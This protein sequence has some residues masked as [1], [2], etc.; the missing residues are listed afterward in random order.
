MRWLISTLADTVRQDL[1]YGVRMMRRGPM[2]SLTAVA[3]VA[4]STAAIA[5]VAALADTLLWRQLQVRDADTF[6]SITATRGRARTDG[7]ISYPDYVTFRDRT[8]TVSPLAA[9][10]STAPLFVAVGG[11][12]AE[13]NGAVVSANYFPLFRIRPV[14]GRFFRAD[15]DR[16]PDRDRVAVIGYDFWQSWFGGSPEAVGSVMTINGVR[17][18]VIGIAPPQ[19]VALTPMPVNLYIPT[20]MLRVGY[21]WCN[22]SLDA[23]CTTLTMV[24]RLSAGRTVPE[25]AAEFAAIMP[26]AWTHAPSGGNSG[27]FVHQ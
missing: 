11:N 5:T 1:G 19:P 9:H 15:E 20:M 24:G 17:F 21:R 7:A 3:T 18:T 25:A 6:V 16:V 27:V 4:L 26:A 12:A 23:D 22:D 10:Y 8:K 13:V 14:L 2:V